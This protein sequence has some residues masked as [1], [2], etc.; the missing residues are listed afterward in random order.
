M[1]VAFD[2]RSLASP[3]LRGWDRYTVGLV[4][5]LVR[6]GVNVTLI[7]RV[8]DPL[9]LPHVEGLGCEVVGLSDRGGMHW[10]QVALPWALRR[11][12]FDL[13][14]APAE[15]GVPLLSPCPVVLTFHSVTLHSYA[16][17]IQRR[18]L[19]GQ[20]RD[21]LGFE[22]KPNG[23]SLAAFYQRAQIA[24]ANHILTPS[25]YCR[26]EVVKFLGVSP[27]RVTTTYLA[28]HEQF[29]RP[30]RTP[31]ERAATLNRLGIKK[32]YLLYVGGY[33]PHK[34]VK[35]LLQT[36]SHVY[37]KQPTMS[38]VMI[39]SKS[40]PDAIRQTSAQLGLQPN[41]DV[42]FLVNI[43]D[44][45][46]DIY[47]EAELLVTLSWR[48]TFCLPALEAMT[49]GI[50][51]VASAWGAGPEVVGEAG[52]LIDPRDTIS[53]S[54]AILKILSATDRRALSSRAKIMAS[55][56]SWAET[57]IQTRRV[58]NNLIGRHA[59]VEYSC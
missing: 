18:L 7:H 48:E 37:A 28:V 53:A 55:K 24:R 30:P 1:R 2:A 38:L 11:G 29:E 51:V 25:N 49:R 44:E 3:V 36:F 31:A 34:N 27:D 4:G 42:V 21:Y 19:H 8:C 33:E 43:T 22:A 32:P 47:D 41:Q 56:F 35:G 40:L 45:L 54:E 14:H 39:G 9:H 58:Y 15:H 59:N 46:T 6:Q 12:D 57:A 10:E 23:W 16:D 13:F 17:L 52:E 20:L 5:E 50:S 26:A